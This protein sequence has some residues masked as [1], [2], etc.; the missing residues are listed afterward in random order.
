MLSGRSVAPLHHVM[1]ISGITDARDSTPIAPRPSSSCRTRRV[2]GQ[3]SRAN[4]ESGGPTACR[5]GRIDPGMRCSPP[6]SL[7]QSAAKPLRN[8]NS[9][10][11][12]N[13]NGGRH[14]HQQRRDRFALR[15]A[16]RRTQSCRGAARHPL[17]RARD[18]REYRRLQPDRHPGPEAAAGRATRSP[19]SG[20]ARWPRR[21][22][23][24][25]RPCV[26]RRVVERLDELSALSG[27][28]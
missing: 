15:R 4:G 25:G 19:V 16:A 24:R 26:G 1:H 14:E 27:A 6:D 3:G 12:R 10:W 21:G 20:R 23:Y 13:C 7:A 5:S 11:P 22:G 28:A 8:S 18:R 17:A 2:S 9:G